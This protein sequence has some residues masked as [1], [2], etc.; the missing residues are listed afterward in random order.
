MQTKNVLIRN[1]LKYMDQFGYK[2]YA[3]FAMFLGIN[4]STL[5][6]WISEKRN[7]TLLSID[8]MANIIELPTYYLLIP[9]VQFI[10]D[11]SEKDRYFPNNSRKIISNN[12]KRIYFENNKITWNE[13]ASLFYGYFSIDTLMSYTRETNYRTP[14]LKRINLMAECLGIEPYKLLKKENK[15]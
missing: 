7:P 3:S 6:C 9:D 15:R 5:K 8:K 4:E 12:L 11:V 13:K 14:P 2:D 10:C 1:L